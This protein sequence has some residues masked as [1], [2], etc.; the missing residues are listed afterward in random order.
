MKVHIWATWQVFNHTPI[1]FKAVPFQCQII[2]L[3][4]TAERSLADI[5][6]NDACHHYGES[7]NCLLPC[8]MRTIVPSLW[9]PTGLSFHAPSKECEPSFMFL[10]YNFVPRG[11]PDHFISENVWLSHI[12]NW[13]LTCS[14][15]CIYP[16]AL[17]SEINKVHQSNRI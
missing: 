13:I 7:V 2:L 8:L 1:T 11:V 6:A 4:A 5:L 16:D 12:Q 9:A 14:T 15:Q 3:L 17:N 10:I